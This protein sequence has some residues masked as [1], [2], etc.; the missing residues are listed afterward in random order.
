[1]WVCWVGVRWLAGGDGDGDGVVGVVV[2][3]MWVWIA[4]MPVVPE[5]SV[6]KVPSAPGRRGERKVDSS[7]IRLFAFASAFAS[8]SALG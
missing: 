4:G 8:L 1:M 5:R 3:D 2:G 6:L 7:V